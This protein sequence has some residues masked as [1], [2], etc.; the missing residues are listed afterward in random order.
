MR[1][2]RCPTPFSTRSCLHLPLSSSPAVATGLRAGGIAAVY[3]NP[4]GR[5]ACRYETYRNNVATGLR[6][7]GISVTPTG[8]DACHYSPYH[9]PW[10]PNSLPATLNC[11]S[12][13]TS[14]RRAPRFSRNTVLRSAGPNCWTP[15]LGRAAQG[16]GV[17]VGNGYVRCLAAECPAH[18][19]LRG[20]ASSIESR[21]GVPG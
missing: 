2:Y 4:T 6:A 19:C 21:L 3:S 18:P 7:G 10:P 8:G 17:F 13:P 9:A 14:P 5:D 16:F 1:R 20:P 12:T 11:R 15:G